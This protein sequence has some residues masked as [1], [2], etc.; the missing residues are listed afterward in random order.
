MNIRIL[1]VEDEPAIQDLL[2]LA[3]RRAGFEVSVANS[4]EEAERSIADMLPDLAIVDWMLPGKSGLAFSTKLRANKRTHDLPIIFLTARVGEEDKVQGL[5][6]GADDY[7]TKPF[8]PKELVARVNALL[9]RRAPHLTD[10]EISVGTLVLNPLMHTVVSAG[11][12]VTMG[13]TEFRLLKFF[14]AHAERVF[15][16]TQLLNAVWGDHV[17]IDDRTIDVHI[18][19]LR[20]ALSPFGME[21]HVQTVRGEGY[22]FSEKIPT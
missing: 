8:S 6:A 12:T 22:R 17:F 1:V 9:R 4:A 21:K 14:M 2:L 10:D 18:R 13:P 16:R 19:R 5:D 3:L 7:M 20:A 11:E 15:S